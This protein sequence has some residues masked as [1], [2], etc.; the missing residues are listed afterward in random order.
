M[1]YD[2]LQL[3]SSGQYEYL[4]IINRIFMHF[5]IRKQDVDIGTRHCG[6][7]P[8]LFVACEISEFKQYTTNCDW[9]SLTCLMG[10]SESRTSKRHI[11][12]LFFF[13]KYLSSVDLPSSTEQCDSKT[14]NHSTILAKNQKTTKTSSFYCCVFVLFWHCRALSVNQTKPNIFT[15]NTHTHTQNRSTSVPGSTTNANDLQC[16]CHRWCCSFNELHYVSSIYFLSV[17]LFYYCIVVWGFRQIFFFHF[18]FHIVTFSNTSRSFSIWNSSFVVQIAFSP[19]HFLI[20]NHTLLSFRFFPFSFSLI[21]FY[22]SY[23]SKEM[24]CTVPDTQPITINH[25]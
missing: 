1:P 22:F 7:I 15:S 6:T 20:V 24:R 21:L 14:A 23:I 17:W 4:A 8:I 11:F 25:E 10:F 3:N 16:R 18:R 5:N 2:Y 19:F 12:H 9:A 13:F